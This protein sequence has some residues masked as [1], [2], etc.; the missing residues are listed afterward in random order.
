VL[1]DSG[2]KVGPL[3]QI[4][5]SAKYLDVAPTT[6]LQDLENMIRGR[7]DE[8]AGVFDRDGAP[9]FAP[10]IGRTH[11]VT[12][13]PEEIALIEPG[14][15]IT[16]SHAKDVTLS[17]ADLGAAKQLD[18]QEIRA[19][20]PHRTFSARRPRS[21]WPTDRKV[22]TAFET[23]YLAADLEVQRRKRMS[24]KPISASKE[25]DFYDEAY[26]QAVVEELRKL[27]VRLKETDANSD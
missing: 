8:V 16:H 11:D 20:G 27:G 26:N 7:G 22:K 21:G 5:A 18:L 14:A 12:F 24:S 25:E 6:S 9:L 15:T 17:L 23:A 1:K 10:K 13:S 3:P 2:H 19:V 4:D